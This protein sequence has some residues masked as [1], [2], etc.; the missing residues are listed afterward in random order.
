MFF[1]QKVKFFSTNHKIITLCPYKKLL[2][3]LGNASIGEGG[4]FLICPKINSPIYCTR[5]ILETEGSVRK[6]QKR[7]G[8]F[9]LQKS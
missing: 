4:P 5:V 6:T 3:N 8:T 7:Q 2:I 1:K 9:S